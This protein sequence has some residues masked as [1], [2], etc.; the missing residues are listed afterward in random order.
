M[1]QPRFLLGLDI[2]TNSVGSAWVDLQDEQL[3]LAVSVFPAGV[4]ETDK[5]RGAP[6]NQTR[7]QK[8]SLRRNLARRSARKRQ[9]R[10]L[11]TERQLLPLDKGELQTLWSKDPWTLRKEGLERALSPFEF[12][13]VLV[14][15]GQHRGAAGLTVVDP[16]NDSAASEKSNVQEGKVKEAIQRATKAITD[17]SARTF[18]EMIA[19]VAA[20][21]RTPVMTS[22]SVP[23]LSLDGAA[24]TYSGRIRNREES[25]EFHAD[26]SMIRDEFSLLWDRQRDFPGALS[27]M[28]TDELRTLLDN[29]IPDQTWRHRGLLFGQRRT[30]WDTGTLGRCVLEP[31]DRCVPIADRHASRFRVVETANNIRI[32]GPEDAEFRPLDGD[33]RQKVIDRLSTQKSGTIATIRDALRIDKRT[34]KK[35]GLSEASYALNL[36]R[37]P[38]REINTDWF[39]D[40]IVQVLG[41]EKWKSWNEAKREALNRAV[42]RF[43]PNDDDTKQFADVLKRLQVDEATIPEVVAGWKSRPKL[44]RRLNLSRRAVM[45]LLPYMERQQEDGRW[46]TQIEA[47]AQFADDPTAIDQ[48]ADAPASDEQRRRYC[49]GGK[50]ANRAMRHFQ[51]KHPDLLPPAPMFA[52]P[53]VRKAI[54]EVRRHV[55]AY[56]KKYRVKPDRIVIELAREAS[57]T[58]KAC[59]AI[60]Q[61]NRLRERIRKNIITDVV[62]PAFQDQFDQLTSNQLRSAV[63]RVVLCMQQGN[64][65]AY[66]GQRL[67]GE[68]SGARVFSGRPIT[69]RQAALGNDVE[70][71]HIMPYSRCGDN[72]LTNKVLCF[73]DSNRNKGRRTPR[74]W[75]GSEFDERCAAMRFMDGYR[76]DDKKS[77]FTTRDYATKWENFNAAQISNEWRGSQLTDT[78]YA[79]K[80]VQRY[81]EQALWPDEPHGEAGSQRRVYVTKGGYT[82]TL[83]RDW[84]LYWTSPMFGGADAN[85][86]GGKNRGDHREHAV[87]ALAIALTDPVRI[88]E[89]ARLTTEV[90]DR[91][92]AARERGAGGRIARDPLAPPWGTRESFREQALASIAEFIRENPPSSA[93][94]QAARELIV[95]HR[96]IG[97]KLRGRLHEDTLFGPTGTDPSLFV[98]RIHAEKLSPN[99][100]RPQITESESDAIARIAREMKVADGTVKPKVARQ[101]ATLIVQSKQYTPRLIDPKPGKSGLVRDPELRR[102][103]RL[104]LNQRFLD[105]EMSCTADNF[106]ESDLKQLLQKDQ[107][108][109]PSGVPILRVKLLRTMND[110]V[111]VARRRWNESKGCWEPESGPRSARAY[112]GG[113]NHHLEI[114]EDEQGN[115][116][117]EVVSAFVAAQRRRLQKVDTIDRSDNPALGGRFVMSLAEGESFYM[118]HANTGEPGYFVVFKLDKPATA[119]FKHHCDARRATGEKDV[120]GKEIPHSRREG[121]SV[122]ASKLK[123][124]APPGEKSPIKVTVHLLEPPMRAEPKSNPS[125][126]LIIDERVMELAREAVALRKSADKTRRARPGSWRWLHRE[127]RSRG[128]DAMAAQLSAA[129]RILKS[130]VR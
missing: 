70:I 54:H 1:T 22:D 38:D 130:G 4:E 11:L 33:E 36:E 42:L 53:V 85:Q 27:P 71:D 51:R 112:I 123:Q 9:L 14:H 103:L 62:R 111:I 126:E 78:A 32:R 35:R 109:K 65:C 43:D 47:R 41:I 61:R 94:G 92:F 124:L 21:R 40:R 96:P 86:P 83:R 66:S 87:D 117:G 58:A 13:R 72:S 2:G 52:N 77:Y 20:E 113:N 50:R 12:G 68:D 119:H 64:V 88:Q 110:P 129:M 10:R 29:P 26:R 6:N 69:L 24:V 121:F 8:R 114:R 122:P 120:D 91:R 60:L 7:R 125:S 76:A 34:L 45:N 30:Y 100:L 25:F 79:T 99:H 98:G 37:D 108:R 81:L 82:A 75:W 46:L 127:L 17:R 80:S 107:L 90:E 95:C 118:R 67:G 101:K 5:G 28:L 39:H 49:L 128:L 97:N 56:L 44:E 23:K 116:S 63:D 102:V 57:K 31:S 93:D 18:G 73:R 106:S 48:I 16:D 74:E 19:N 105:A 3:D 84:E 15:L 115:W 55:I 89:L 104:V 59:D